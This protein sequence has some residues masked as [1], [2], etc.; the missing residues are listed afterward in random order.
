MG[1]KGCRQELAASE[2]R[3]TR[4]IL[5]YT[6]IAETGSREAAGGGPDSP[7]DLGFYTLMSSRRLTDS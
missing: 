7:R 5:I 2:G 1:F 3:R 6:N 4:E